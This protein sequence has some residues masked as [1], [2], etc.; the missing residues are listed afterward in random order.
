MALA[1]FT[2]SGSKMQA[3]QFDGGG[4]AAPRQ[5]IDPLGRAKY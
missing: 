1:G 4:A 5:Q 2:G 3:F